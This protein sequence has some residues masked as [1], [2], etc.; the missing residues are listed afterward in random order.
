[1]TITQFFCENNLTKLAVFYFGD[2]LD[3]TIYNEDNPDDIRSVH[4]TVKDAERLMDELHRVII[5]IEKSKN[6]K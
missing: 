3:I 2:L 1:M 4:I 5:E 6:N